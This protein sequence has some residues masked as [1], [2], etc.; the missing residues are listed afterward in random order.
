MCT[1]GHSCATSHVHQCASG[2]SRFT[3]PFDFTARKRINT[4]IDTILILLVSELNSLLLC[5]LNMGGAAPRVMASRTSMEK[6]VAARSSVCAA[7]KRDILEVSEQ[8][9]ETRV[10][11]ALGEKGA[12]C[13]FVLLGTCEGDGCGRPVRLQT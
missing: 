2:K 7:S 1:P 8:V 3:T 12:S 6:G 11:K 4:A 9:P 10:S 5:L 13:N